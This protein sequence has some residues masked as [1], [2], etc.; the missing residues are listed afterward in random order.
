MRPLTLVKIK[1]RPTQ[2]KGGPEWAE[3]EKRM[4]RAEFS[5]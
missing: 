5:I 4:K 3:R 2:G 1:E